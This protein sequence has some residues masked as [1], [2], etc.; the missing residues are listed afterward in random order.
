[1][2]RKR[3]TEKQIAFALRQAEG[4]MLDQWAHLNGV[5]IDF[6]RPS[7]LAPHTPQPGCRPGPC[8]GVPGHPQRPTTGAE[9]AALP[10]CAFRSRSI[11]SI[12][13]PFV[14]MPRT[15]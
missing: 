4:G 12:E 14:S 13:R 3:Y 15:R 7:K 10:D 1:M 6:S 2:K 5:E 11:C 8:N 9:R